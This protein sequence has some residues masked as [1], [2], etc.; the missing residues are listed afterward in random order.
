MALVVS[1]AQAVESVTDDEANFVTEPWL[2]RWSWSIG[3][4]S[5]KT[6]AGTGALLA[7]LVLVPEISP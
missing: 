6:T 4:E 2:G 1:G 5:R 3:S 7:R